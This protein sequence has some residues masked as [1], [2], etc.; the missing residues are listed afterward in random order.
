MKQ[1]RRLRYSVKKS[2][3][4]LRRHKLKAGKVGQR[5]DESWVACLTETKGERCEGLSILPVRPAQPGK[6]RKP[7]TFSAS[8]WYAGERSPTRGTIRIELTV[9]ASEGFDS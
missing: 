4:S 8:S 5:R 9:G 7:A 6:L 1:I 2:R 3:G